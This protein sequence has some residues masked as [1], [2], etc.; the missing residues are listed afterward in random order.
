MAGGVLLLGMRG[1]RRRIEVEDHFRGRCAGRPRARPCLCAR[2]AHAIELGRADRQ[3]RPPSRRDRRNVAE[4]RRLGAEGDQIR[5]AAPAVGQHHRQIAEHPPRVM[6]RATLA[7]LGQR[8]PQRVTQP[9]PLRRQPQHAVPARDDSPMPSALTSTFC[10][11]ERPITF[12]VRLLSGR[13]GSRQPQL[14][15]LR[16]TFQ[17]AAASRSRS[18]MANRG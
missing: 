15:L 8:P 12:K 18:L 10:M 3:Q 1:D 5:Y 6:R 13:E 2:R 16:R 14:S 7:R 17:P 11:L 4:Q 9:Q